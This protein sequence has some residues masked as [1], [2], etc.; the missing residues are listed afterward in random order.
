MCIY[1]MTTNFSAIRPPEHA[2]RVNGLRY[3]FTTREIYE[4]RAMIVGAQHTHVSS[5]VNCNLTASTVSRL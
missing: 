1:A 5:S 3:W 4:A 2:G